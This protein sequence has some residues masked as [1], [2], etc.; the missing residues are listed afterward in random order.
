MSLNKQNI[1]TGRICFKNPKVKGVI[2]KVKQNKHVW[3]NTSVNFVQTF[4]LVYF[5]LS[6]VSIS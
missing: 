2:F 4:N 5:K 6:F 1:N 3:D